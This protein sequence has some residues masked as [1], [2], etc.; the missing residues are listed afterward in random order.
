MPAACACPAFGLPSC[1]P[2]GCFCSSQWVQQLGC[3][4]APLLCCP[5]GL[6]AA[7]LRSSDTSCHSTLRIAGQAERLHAAVPGRRLR[8]AHGPGQGGLLFLFGLLFFPICLA[9][10]SRAAP[11]TCCGRHSCLALPVTLS[12]P[13]VSANPLL[14][15]RC[16]GSCSRGPSCLPAECPCSAACLSPPIAFPTQP[17][18]CRCSRSCSRASTSPP[19][20]RPTSSTSCAWPP[21][22]PA[23][24]ACARWV[25]ACYRWELPGV[26][27]GRIVADRQLA[28]Y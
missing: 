6:P 17:S 12:A 19:A 20:P 2:P 13:A 18:A 4:L 23:T 27:A 24:C 22:A 16:A 9:A 14:L 3:D 15:R 26:A 21:T 10:G 7:L 5:Q 1:M 11:T 8:P 28:T 25:P